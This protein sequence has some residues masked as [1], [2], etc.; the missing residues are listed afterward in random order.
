M[1]LARTAAAESKAAAV[2]E[3]LARHAGSHLDIAHDNAF[4]RAVYRMYAPPD[5]NGKMHRVKFTVKDY[6]GLDG[7]KELHALAALK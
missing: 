6:S 2:I 3:E 5:I 1:E 4:V 7:K